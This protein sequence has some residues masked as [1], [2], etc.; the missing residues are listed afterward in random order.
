[1]LAVVKTALK[2]IVET[3][4]GTEATG[5]ID[6]FAENLKLD[7]ESGFIPLN[8]TG[9]AFGNTQPGIVPLRTGVCSCRLPL[10][11]NG[12]QGLESGLAAFL[13]AAA[14]KK[15]LESY[16]L[17]NGFS[18]QSC[19]SVDQFVDG[20]IETLYGAMFDAKFSAEVGGPGWF[21][22]DGKGLYKPEDDLTF[23][24]FA[25]SARSPMILQAA[26]L[27]FD[28]YAF[29]ISKFALNLGNQVILRPDVVSAG[30]YGH[31]LITNYN[32]T[33]EIDPEDV[34]VSAYNYYSKLI[35]RATTVSALPDLVLAFSDG[36]DKITFT[37]QAV[38]LTECPHDERE[39][40]RT[41]KYVGRLHNDGS[42][43]P[44]VIA[45]TAP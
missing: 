4:K 27:T 42:T 17:S 15:T 16:A 11:G 3:V 1:M 6:V 7:P 29:K 23:P 40:L 38:Q 5:N 35:T 39:G 2:V 43:S 41:R 31:A 22:F 12:S 28:S 19:L 30:G 45:V 14:F 8:G 33:I 20:K 13:Q 32:P 10:R 44:V 26:T 21:E 18:D 36:T 25:P 37:L 34:T 24:S 9:A